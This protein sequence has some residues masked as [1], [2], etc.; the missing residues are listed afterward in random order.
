MQAVT[1]YELNTRIKGV[2][3]QNFPETV[4]ITAEITEIQLNRSG[5][6][7][8]QL[9]DK[10]EEDD[11][12]IATARATIWAFTFRTLQPYFET[13]T[14]RPLGK[15]M[16]VMLLVE[17]VFH[18]L[19]GYSL[20]VRDIDPTYTIG[21]LERKKQEILN[22]L[23]REGIINMNRE[24]PFPVLPK[25]I[26][27]ISSPTAAG[28]GDFMNQLQH[29]S[30]HYQ[31]HVHLFPAVMQG[32]KTTESVIAA[33][34][35]IY[36]YE[37]LFDVV[38]LIRGGGSQT[39]L[40]S[41]DTY[42]I[43]ANIAQFPLPII[44]GIGHERDETIA[45]RVAHLRVKTPTAAAVFLIET[46]CKQE[47]NLVDLQTVFVNGIQ[48][49]L[50]EETTRQLKAT[51]DFKRLVSYLLSDKK[52]DLRMLSQRVG[53]ASSAFTAQRLHYF[54]QMMTRVES[55]TALGFTKQQ[56]R[57][58][59]L[60]RDILREASAILAE[61]KRRLELAT[62]MV[63][64]VDPHQVLQRGYS[65]TRLNGKAVKEA[66]TLSPGDHLET[67]LA[68]GSIKSIVIKND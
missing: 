40:G 6:C 29:N 51:A 57:L 3:K 45:D 47:E 2:L 28:L 14:G 50:H 44:A 53:Y 58:D 24:L 39:D 62:T 61:H 36:E 5:H 52:S 67:Q 12:V 1:L 32:N 25:N 19:Y 11:S 22:Q 38:V 13:T 27:V 35:R 43:A 20:N 30:Y 7:Y 42:D 4:W 17:V 64:Y 26:A 9:V 37:S 23:E 21:D 10:R 15:G 48:D 46:F 59:G 66:V 55:R 63:K 68:G 18:E 60:E 65:I 8:L 16:K 41:F 34:D 49:L 33:L 54:M 31:F 56:N